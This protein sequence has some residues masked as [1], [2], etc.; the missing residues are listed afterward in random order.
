MD[1]FDIVFSAE[2]IFTVLRLTTPIIFAMLSA[3]I[4][5]KCGVVNISTEGI[6]LITALSSALISA[7]TQSIGIALLSSMLIG[8][9]LGVIFI[10]IVSKL[11]ANPIL[12]ALAI[13]IIASGGTVFL[14]WV[15]TGD[16]STTTS[17]SSLKVPQVNIPVL[18]NIPILGV[19]LSGHS[20]LTYISFLSVIL[21]NILLYKT[22]LGLRIRAVG[23]DEST[24]RS[25]GID[26]NKIRIISLF[27]SGALS[28]LGGAY[29]S[30][31]Y[32][33]WFSANMVA[34]RGFIGLAAEAMGGGTPYGGLIV[35]IFFGATDAIANVFQTQASIPSEAIQMIPYIC[36]I[37]GLAVISYLKMKKEMRI[38]K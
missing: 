13:N 5:V 6:M 12:T 8:G 25:V 33:S 31:S 36:T 21:L 29:M 4:S 17:L 16:K 11:N 18:K 30:M 37:V 28:G 1:F 35:S 15:L 26:V 23:E 7:Y 34:G 3:V 24:A 2:F 9:L 10:L 20:L 19:A 27:I 38:I 22:P 14:L 32:L